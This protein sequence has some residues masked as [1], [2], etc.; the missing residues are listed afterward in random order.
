MSTAIKK[1]RKKNEQKSQSE[2]VA[3]RQRALLK[4]NSREILLLGDT[5]HLLQLYVFLACF[6]KTLSA[7]DF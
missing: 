7:F 1:I 2:A 5:Y 3:Y 4:E 6:L